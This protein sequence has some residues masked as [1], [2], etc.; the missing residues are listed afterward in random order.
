VDCV[1]DPT[2][3]VR[4]LMR[5]VGMLS[6]VNGDVS[7]IWA[8]LDSEI[9]KVSDRFLRNDI[10]REVALTQ[11]RTGRVVEAQNVASTLRDPRILYNIAT[12][13][14][15]HGDTVG[16]FVTYDRSF[17]DQA[18]GLNQIGSVIAEM[19]DAGIAEAALGYYLPRAACY[20]ESAWHSCGI[21][22]QLYPEKATEL[23]NCLIAFSRKWRTI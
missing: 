20:V 1:E 21:I 7:T 13:Q 5:I 17:A 16:A 19:R 22:A 18:S 9:S 23:A 12:M 4:I 2:I 8:K 6:S 10:L 15:Q 14:L 11:A 3:K